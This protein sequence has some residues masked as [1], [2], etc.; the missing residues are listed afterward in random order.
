MR[1]YPLYMETLPIALIAAATAIFV[2]QCWKFF[3]PLLHGKPPS[4]RKALQS[5]GMPSSH[6]AAAAS[7]TLVTGFHEGF[8]SSIFAVALVLTAI[9]AHDAVKVRGTINTIIR[10]LKKTVP[11]EILKEEEKLP[12]SVGH[13]ISEVIAGFIL[14][15]LIAEVFNLFFI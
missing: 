15:G 9:V 6:T 11:P 4:F 14:A 3:S 7:M 5:G 2:G 12:D 10:I 1:N 13:S 8:N